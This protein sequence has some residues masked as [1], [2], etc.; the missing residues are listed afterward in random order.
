MQTQQ[1][2]RIRLYRTLFQAQEVRRISLRRNVW[3]D[4]NRGRIPTAS[5]S[6]H[7]MERMEN[8]I[9]ELINAL[10]SSL[11]PNNSMSQPTSSFLPPAK[12]PAIAPEDVE[13][14]DDDDNATRPTAAG[15][16]VSE[17]RSTYN[18]L[19]DRRLPCSSGNYS[20]PRL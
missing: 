17:E 9:H 19:I 13:T 10:Q 15:T 5:K 8:S 6:H 1:M 3:T 11:K 4:L 12:H 16:D 20:W 18:D 14:D 2:S 7:R